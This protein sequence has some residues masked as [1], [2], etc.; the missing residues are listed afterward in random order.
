M[1]RVGCERARLDDVMLIA[2]IKLTLSLLRLMYN[3]YIYGTIMVV[4][5]L[6]LKSVSTDIHQ[7]LKQAALDD[8]RSLNSYI[9]SLLELSVQE[10]RRRRGMRE[11]W[12]EFR[13][14]VHSLPELSD[15]TEL[16]RQDR[17]RGH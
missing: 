6:T 7:E 2:R 10:R 9:L 4:P 8:G 12:D 14:F 17:E 1:F 5:N 11:G 16:L 3:G 13:R 15:S